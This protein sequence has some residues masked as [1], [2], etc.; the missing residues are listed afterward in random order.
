MTRVRKSSLLE[1]E[2]SIPSAVRSAQA[3]IGTHK[4]SNCPSAPTVGILT[5]GMEKGHEAAL[6]AISTQQRWQRGVHLSGAQAGQGKGHMG[7]KGQVPP[8]PALTEHSLK[9]SGLIPSIV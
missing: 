6:W 4:L 7:A 3:Q 9:P 5:S 1:Q 8:N 2:Q